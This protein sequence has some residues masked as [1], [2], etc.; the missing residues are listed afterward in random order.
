LRQN[1]RDAIS[2]VL[3]TWK[4]DFSEPERNSFFSWKGDFSNRK[5]DAF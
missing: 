4:S 3:V 5:G 1:N 2:N